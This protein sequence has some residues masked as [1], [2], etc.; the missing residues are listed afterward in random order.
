M[1]DDSDHPCYGQAARSST[2]SVRR[3]KDP[4]KVGE[5]GNAEGQR[6]EIATAD[7]LCG[8]N[9]HARDDIQRRM[10]ERMPS[11]FSRIVYGDA[12]WNRFTG[13]HMNVNNHGT[14]CL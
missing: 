11:Q 14:A 7:G 8:T 6:Y 10:K 9:A 3:Q 12:V 5:H 13:S 4:M 1:N 2:G